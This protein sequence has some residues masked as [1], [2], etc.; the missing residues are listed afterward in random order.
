MPISVKNKAPKKASYTVDDIVEGIGSGEVKR[1]CEEHG[2]EETIYDYTDIVCDVFKNATRITLSLTSDPEIE[3][4]KMIKIN[5]S[6]KSDIETVLK[7]DEELFKMID[8][9]IPDRD[10]EYFVKTYDLI[11]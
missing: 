8:N 3:G 6:T 1:F 10:N 5:I 2:L 11:E 9:N 4:R 7:L